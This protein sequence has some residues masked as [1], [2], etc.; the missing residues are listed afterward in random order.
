MRREAIRS[1]RRRD[2]IIRD[3]PLIGLVGGQHPSVVEIVK[4]VPRCTCTI[5]PDIIGVNQHH[6]LCPLRE[7]R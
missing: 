1:K 2:P 3:A 7:Q 6:G 4:A 5:S